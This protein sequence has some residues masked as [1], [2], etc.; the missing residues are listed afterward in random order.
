MKL[1]VTAGHAQIDGARKRF[2]DARMLRWRTFAFVL[3]ALVAL[4]GFAQEPD[5]A[6]FFDG[7]QQ[8][9]ADIRK[10]LGAEIDEVKLNDFRDV[11]TSI[12][13]SADALAA[14]RAPKLD[15]LD[16]RIAEI[17]RKSVV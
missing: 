9:I 5:S 13:A 3:L 4:R 11:A 10:Q 1:R 7:A 15:A 6:K 17:D 14:D 12:G 2:D 16:A 8:Q